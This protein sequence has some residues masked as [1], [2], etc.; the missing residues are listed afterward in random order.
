[1][2]T[3]DL[4][5]LP[6]KFIRHLGREYNPGVIESQT[7]GPETLG[8]GACLGLA[9]VQGSEH[10]LQSALPPQ[11]EINLDKKW[12]ELFFENSFHC[13]K[14]QDSC[15]WPGARGKNGLTGRCFTK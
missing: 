4:R 9:Q 13:G 10:K 14:K 1:M 5:V 8:A 2:K 3:P 12:Q 15:D 7:A 11:R 6:V